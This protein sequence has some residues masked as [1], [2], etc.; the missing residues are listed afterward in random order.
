MKHDLSAGE[1]RLVELMQTLGFGRI[2]GLVI[3]HGQPVFDPAPRVVRE[4]KFGA[5]N[6]PR[7]ELAL[8]DFA[9]KREVMDL[10]EALRG[11]ENGA[12]VSIETKYGMPFKM[13]VSSAQWGRETKRP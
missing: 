9:L 10:F 5:E 13:T 11:L 4:I 12:T 2:M 7:P 8:E 6:G 1:A 3:V